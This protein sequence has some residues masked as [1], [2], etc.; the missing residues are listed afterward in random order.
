MLVYL[1][2]YCS[3]DTSTIMYWA[4]MQVIIMVSYDLFRTNLSECFLNMQ[5]WVF[6]LCQSFIMVLRWWY[7]GDGF[8]GNKDIWLDLIRMENCLSVESYLETIKWHHFQVKLHQNCHCS[9]NVWYHIFNIWIICMQWKD[10]NK[11]KNNVKG[12]RLNFQY[13]DGYF[14]IFTNQVGYKLCVCVISSIILC[15]LASLK[16]QICKIWTCIWFS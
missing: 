9:Q 13:V 4:T 12:I 3:A 11:A 2:V 14:S 1:L 8:F 5:G 16:S 15:I 7:I 6:W 10:S